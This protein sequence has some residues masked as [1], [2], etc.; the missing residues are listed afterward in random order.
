MLHFSI[1]VG[2]ARHQFASLNML[3]SFL[4][5][6]KWRKGTR[7]REGGERRR[8]ELK[9]KKEFVENRDTVYV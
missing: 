3:V 8:I 7:E 9:R 6:E 5:S 1:C 4:Y 2:N